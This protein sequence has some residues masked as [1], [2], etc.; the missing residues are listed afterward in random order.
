VNKGL[1]EIY[2]LAG[3]S[4]GLTQKEALELAESKGLRLISNKEADQILVD[5]NL[6]KKY[7][8]YW[9]FWTSTRVKING[10]EC[11]VTEFDGRTAKKKISLEDGWF[12]QDEFGLP[13]G[14]KSNSGNIDARF[15]WRIKKYVGLVARGFGGRRGVGCDYCD[16]RFGVLAVKKEEGK[17]S[18]K[19]KL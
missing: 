17:K 11:V 6:R 19:V 1:G 12:L 5:D 4:P 15:L 14:K 13:F 3:Y 10:I 8:D 18:R 9:P 16:Y 2:R 7:Y